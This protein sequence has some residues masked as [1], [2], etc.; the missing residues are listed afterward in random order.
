MVTLI[1]GRRSGPIGGIGSRGGQARQAGGPGMVL[2]LNRRAPSDRPSP[3]C[4][5]G[6]RSVPALAS[7][8]GTDCLG[9]RTAGS[10]RRGLG[11][12][13]RTGYTP[14]VEAY[15]GALE[16]GESGI[17]F[18]AF[19]RPDTRYGPR[20][21]WF[22]SGAFLVVEPDDGRDVAKLKVAFVKITQDLLEEAS[23]WTA[24]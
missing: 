9:R 1:A 24:P 19:E 5:N 14:T 7:G 21:R 6:V 10:Q 12:V 18:W 23:K 20:P 3:G 15:P 13:P 11:E 2:D 4:R 8:E 22:R 17:E 16:S